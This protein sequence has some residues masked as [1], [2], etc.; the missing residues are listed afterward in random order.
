[1]L[2][3]DVANEFNKLAKLQDRSLFINPSTLVALKPVAHSSRA[4]V[5]RGLEA[6]LG[7]GLECLV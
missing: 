5:A 7:A 1:M 4:A 6:G 3:A 2:I